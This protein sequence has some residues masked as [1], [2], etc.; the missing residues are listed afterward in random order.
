MFAEKKTEEINI[1]TNL[2]PEKTSAKKT[3]QL[4]LNRINGPFLSGGLPSPPSPFHEV[5][6]YNPADKKND[7]ESS[8]GFD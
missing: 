8:K 5:V 2:E 7:Q 1:L 4:Q 3:P 6:A